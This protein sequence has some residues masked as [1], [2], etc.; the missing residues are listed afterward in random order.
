MRFVH[1]F[2]SY[3]FWKNRK[4][5]ALWSKN[6]IYWFLDYI[7]VIFMLFGTISFEISLFYNYENNETILGICNLKEK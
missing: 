2:V 6:K 7:T 5:S 1:M 4:R 3:L